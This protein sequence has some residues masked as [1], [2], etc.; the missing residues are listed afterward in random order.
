[1]KA[2]LANPFGIWLE[3]AIKECLD[4]EAAF[5]I[6]RG[7]AI[8]VEELPD[9]YKTDPDPV[10]YCPVEAA[11]FRVNLTVNGQ[12]VEPFGLDAQEK[13]AKYQKRFS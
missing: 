2:R 3:D 1:M 8:L 9:F 12:S 11:T 4:E 7:Y 6:E 10:S 5:L 13:A